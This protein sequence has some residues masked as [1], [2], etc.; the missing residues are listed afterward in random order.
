MNKKKSSS[1]S[2]F[3]SMMSTL[4]YDNPDIGKNVTNVDT[5]DTF[6]DVE[7]QFNTD[8]PDVKSEDDDTNTNQN[9]QN[10][11]GDDDSK[12]PDEVLDQMNNNNNNTN[13][14]NNDL[15]QNTTDV[16]DEDLAEATQIGVLFDA[17]AESF[18][19]N[20]EDIEEESRPVTVEGL[21]DYLKQV[22]EQNSTPQYADERI[23]HLDEYVKNGGK[24]EDFYASQAQELNYDNIDIENESDQRAVVK[25]LLKHNGYT[26]QQINN[27][28][29]RYEDADM[30]AEEAEE[31]IARLKEIRQKE[32]EEMLHQ[33]EEARKQQQAQQMQFYNDVDQQIKNLNSI[34]GI[35]IPKEDRKAL[36]DY[37]FKLDA[38]GVSQYQKDF[39]KNLSKN[40]IESAYFTMKADA[41]INGAKKTG[42]TTAAQKLREMLRHTSKNHSSFNAQE[43]KQRQAWEI[44][45]KFL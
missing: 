33:Q 44:A 32:N 18:G 40:L 37:I 10:T 11:S 39:N 20:I 29:S 7:P 24:F 1:P 12:I 23:Q 45:S 42:E 16:S 25:E 43:E 9:V 5:M 3:D 21:T 36:F 41:L 35:A 38:N 19:W 26:D 30:L 27:K 17:V 8:E 4:G 34:R 6:E 14:D 15:N 2:A 28:I 31:A 22:V 13:T